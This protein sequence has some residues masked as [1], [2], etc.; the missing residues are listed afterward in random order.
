[1]GRLIGFVLGLVGAI[2]VL[3]LLFRRKKK[4]FIRGVKNV[5]IVLGPTKDGRCGATVH[6]D[7]VTL[8]K[9]GDGGGDVVRWNI[10]NPSECAGTACDGQ[11]EVCVDKWG[12][13]EKLSTPGPWDPSEPPV[14]PPSTGRFCRDVK[15]GQT[16]HLPAQVKQNARYGYYKYSVFVGDHEAVDPIVRVVI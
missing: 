9:S 7:E 8:S 2:S 4:E 6:P 14:K 16:K 15:P 12:F 5:D 10:T 1:V 3:L 11:V 13:K